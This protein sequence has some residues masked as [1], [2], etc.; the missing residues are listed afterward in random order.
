MRAHDTL[1][2]KVST[3]LVV[4]V[5]FYNLGIRNGHLNISNDEKIR[6]QYFAANLLQYPVEGFKLHTVY[7]IQKATSLHLIV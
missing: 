7:P 4:G 5:P 6:V 2:M 1:A 3:Y